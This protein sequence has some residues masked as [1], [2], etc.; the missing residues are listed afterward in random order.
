MSTPFLKKNN[1]NIKKIIE[2][3]STSEVQDN[4]KYLLSLKNY[5]LYDIY[6]N[7]LTR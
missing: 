1:L 6:Y 7:L 5:V 3:F 4:K 2:L